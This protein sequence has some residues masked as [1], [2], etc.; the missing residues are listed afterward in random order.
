MKNALISPN[1]QV[2]YVSGWD[3]K[4]PIYTVIGQRVAEVADAEFPIA[5]PL[6]WMACADDVVAD[7]YYYDPTDST[8]KLMPEP[9]PKPV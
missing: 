8:I 5:P 1:E 4:F 2:G 3:G 7:V 9:V 6:F